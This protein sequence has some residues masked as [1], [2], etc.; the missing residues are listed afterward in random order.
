[1]VEKTRRQR[2]EVARVVALVAP[3]AVAFGLAGACAQLKGS[4]G[5][6]CLK[7]EDCQSGICSEQ[8]CAAQPTLL[9]GQVTPSGGPDA[10][11]TDGGQPDGAGQVPDGGTKPSDAGHDASETDA[12]ND[13]N[14]S[15]P[16]AA[17]ASSTP[18]GDLDALPDEAG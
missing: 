11:G 18:D 4:L 8:H 17:D 2:R 1:M 7:N 13:A 3:I 14:S 15:G 5:D 6:D 9:D 16:D 10:A 12:A